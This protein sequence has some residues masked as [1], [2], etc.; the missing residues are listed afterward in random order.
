MPYSPE[1][2]F[3]RVESDRRTDVPGSIAA[4]EPRE[5][6]LI[7]AVL[8][9]DARKGVD[10]LLRALAKM[11]ESHVVFRAC[12]VG[13]GM[14]IDQHRRMV[15]RLNLSGAVTIE[16][17]VPDAY[18]YMRHADVFAL[19]SFEES[20]GSV[21]LLEALQVGVAFVASNVDGIPEDV[22]DGDSALLVE[23]GDVSALSQALG[24]ALTD[25]TMRHRLARR[26]RGVFVE[27]FSPETFT[28]AVRATY[29]ELEQ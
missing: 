22:T 23:P 13:G 2:A 9:H 16:G 17:F 8:R 25:A 10:V 21:S 18:A 24:R 4:L 3:T 27:R 1:T 29:A 11:R 6:P 20:S 7:V 5:A 12:L 14:L 19:P 28:E 26:A 15:E